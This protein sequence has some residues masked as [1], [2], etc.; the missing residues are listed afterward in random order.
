MPREPGRYDAV[1]AALHA[2]LNAALVVL[3]V[4]DGDM[5]PAVSMAGSD[6]V[7]AKLPELLRAL[8][9]TTEQEQQNVQ[10]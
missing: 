3:I 1:S 10:L 9:E 6:S 4:I 2:S 8:A 5:Q 7:V